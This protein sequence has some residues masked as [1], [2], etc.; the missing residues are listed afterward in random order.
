MTTTNPEDNVRRH[1]ETKLPEFD[2]LPFLAARRVLLFGVA[3]EE[4]EQFIERFYPIAEDDEEGRAHQRASIAALA[5]LLSRTRPSVDQPAV[6]EHGDGSERGGSFLES[7]GVKGA[8]DALYQKAKGLLDWQAVPRY[9]EKTLW[10]QLVDRSEEKHDGHLTILRFP[11]NWRVGF[12][13]PQCREDV[14][15]LIA[16]ETFEEAA[17]KA[18]DEP[19]LEQMAPSDP[20][21]LDDLRSLI[22]T[23]AQHWS[24]LL[25]EACYLVER[26]VRPLALLDVPLDD[27]DQARQLVMER[28]LH[29]F[30]TGEPHEDLSGLQVVE[31]AIA[32]EPWVLS[33]YRRSLDMGVEDQASL[34]GLLLGYSPRSIQEFCAALRGGEEGRGA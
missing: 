15:A 32:A 9:G 31:F 1:P 16:G 8:R 13:T 11:T 28:D 6:P 3:G 17:R 22:D 4:A 30:L 34:V 21:G 19:V 14:S 7:L 20:P 25:E 24:W 2:P 27:Y 10:Q 5:E 18:L 12:I 29:L 26:G 33:L 23:P